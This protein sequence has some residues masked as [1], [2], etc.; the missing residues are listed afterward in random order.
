MTTTPEFGDLVLVRFPFPDQ[1]GE[2]Y[3]PS[4]VISNRTFNEAGLDLVCMVVSGHFPRVLSGLF[5]VI[6]DWSAAGLDRPSVIK[7]VISSVK[8]SLQP[9]LVGRLNQPTQI[10]LRAL[11]N[12]MLA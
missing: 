6:Q 10:E 5:V 1:S 8:R 12:R 3:R 11:V 7:P 4:V 9:R 2:K